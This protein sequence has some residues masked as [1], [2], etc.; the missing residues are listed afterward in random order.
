MLYGKGAAQSSL[1]LDVTTVD[2][3]KKIEFSSYCYPNFAINYASWVQIT[4]VFIIKTEES[5]TVLHVIYCEIEWN[6]PFYLQ[7]S[8]LLH[9]KSVQEQKTCQSSLSIQETMARPAVQCKLA[10]SRFAINH[11]WQGIRD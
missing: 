4:A 1:C 9:L 5:V 10:A 3:P 6:A 8:L 7:G 11:G 2:T